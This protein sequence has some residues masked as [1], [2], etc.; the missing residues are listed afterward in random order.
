MKKLLTIC[1]IATLL[2]LTA[3]SKNVSITIIDNDKSV[4]VEAK[5]GITVSELLE[6]ES[7]ILN[8]KDETEPILSSKITPDSSEIIIKRYAKVT[9][10]K[11]LET[12]EVELIGGTV[13]DAIKASGFKIESGEELNCKLSD[14][15]VNEMT[16]KIEREVTITL[17]VDGTTADIKTKSITVKDFLDEQHITL[18]END[19]VNGTNDALLK[20]NMSIIIKRVTYEKESKTKSVAYKTIEKPDDSMYKGERRII[21]EGIKGKKEVTYRIKYI[22]GKKA[23]QEKLSEIIT[24]EPVNRI[25]TYGTKE[26]MLTKNEAEIIVKKHWGITQNTGNTYAVVSDGLKSYGNKNYYAFRC[27][28]RVDEIGGQFHYS[29]IDFKY[30]NAYTGEIVSYIS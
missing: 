10:Q 3:C 6:Q 25:I 27:M 5:T 28:W 15:L 2:L 1:T 16:I 14:L 30:V 8:S 17:S 24:E 21:Q 23:K 7:V 9:I 26:K 19:E 11:G 12:K 4:I 13:Q 20:D 22:D 29:T 18:N